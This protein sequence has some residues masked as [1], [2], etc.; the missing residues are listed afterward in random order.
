MGCVV[1]VYGRVT[2]RHA[3]AQD[4]EGRVLEHP[5][6]EQLPFPHGKEYK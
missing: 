5:F 4:V 3:P 2:E 1:P 6:E